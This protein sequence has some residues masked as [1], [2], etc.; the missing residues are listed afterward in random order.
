MN[1]RTQ[2]FTL[3]ELLVVIAIIGVLAALLLSSY[4]SAQQRPYDVAALQCGRA[5]VTAELAW[6][7]QK[8]SYTTSLTELGQDVQE[9]CTDA[10][11][12]V[13]ADGENLSGPTMTPT[14]TISA[15]A[16][17]F[18]FRVFHPSGSGYYSYNNQD[19]TRANGGKLNRLTNW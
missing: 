13:A 12:R 5:I 16:G 3:I 2:G 8:G 17:N 10:E 15:G 18:A 1:N 6:R 19:G 9:A 7:L 14:N 4:R 11:V